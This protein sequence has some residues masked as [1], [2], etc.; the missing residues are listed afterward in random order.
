MKI[1]FYFPLLCK[2]DTAVSSNIVSALKLIW[3]FKV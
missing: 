3:P 2:R 1:P